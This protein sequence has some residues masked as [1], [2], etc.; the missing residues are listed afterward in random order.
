M[1]VLK[2]RNKLR[3]PKLQVLRSMVFPVYRNL[4][5]AIDMSSTYMSDRFV[6]EM[7]F[8][9]CIQH[10]CNKRLKS[11]NDLVV[12]YYRSGYLTQ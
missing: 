8:V 7:Y 11:D 4:N 10:L 5:R 9:S 12:Y 1:A 6:Y 2:I 3:V